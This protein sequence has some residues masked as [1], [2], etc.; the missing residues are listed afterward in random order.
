MNRPALLSLFLALCACGFAQEPRNIGVVDIGVDNR[1]IP[2]RVSSDRPELNSLAQQAFGSHGRYRVVAAGYRYDIR[3]SL[4]G[5]DA[6]EVDVNGPEGQPLAAETVPGTSE[7]NA[8]LRAA[9]F[10]VERTNGLGLRGF[11]ASKLVCIGERTGHKEIYVGDLYFGNLRQITNDRAIAMTPR[12]SPD[13]RKILYTSFYHSG[14]P[15]LFVIDL[16]TYERTTFASFRGTNSGGRYSPDGQRVAMVL[17][18]EGNPEIY[19]SNAQGRGVSRR[20]RYDSVKSSPCWSPDGREIVFASGNPDP[21]LY[22]IPAS[23]FGAMRRITHGISFY[24]AEPDWSRADPDKIALTAWVGGSYQIVVLS[25][26]S[27]QWKQVSHAPFDGIEPSW[28]AD[29]RHLVYTARDRT[30]SRVCILDTETGKSTPL[31]PLS[32][33]STLQANVWAP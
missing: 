29:G 33:G 11:F 10:A 23:G 24:C 28:L 18:G 31:S 6:V 25:V 13:G 2:V 15:D 1:T 7:R 8:L 19:V 12:W 5:A 9:D 17:T 22:V 16:S 3:F 26:S 20:T 4:A 32:F 30:R 27:G 21:Q 14:F